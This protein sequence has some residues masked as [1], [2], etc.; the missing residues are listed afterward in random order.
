MRSAWR[1]PAD[2]LQSGLCDMKI[3]AL[4]IAAPTVSVQARPLKRRFTE[5]DDEKGVDPDSDELYGWV[6]DDEVAAEGLLVDEAT[7]PGDMDAAEAR[8][9]AAELQ[10]KKV[11]RPATT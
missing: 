2:L 11:T 9:D 7:I 8:N 3:A 6:E 5:I 1:S 4:D 10:G